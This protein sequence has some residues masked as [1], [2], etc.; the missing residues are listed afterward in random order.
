MCERAFQGRLGGTQRI[1]RVALQAPPQAATKR[2]LDLA[3]GLARAKQEASQP[4]A[5]GAASLQRPQAATLSQLL[6][7]GECPPVALRA[8]GKLP[9]AKQRSGPRLEHRERVAPSVRVDADDEVG[10]L[11]EHGAPPSIGGERVGVGLAQR[12]TTAGL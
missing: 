12:A 3:H 1:E 10:R 6:R 8:G 2:S 5:V 9:L 4:G 7:A 11:C